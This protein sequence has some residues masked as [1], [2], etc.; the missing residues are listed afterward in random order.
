MIQSSSFI[1]DQ[2]FERERERERYRMEG[3]VC[4]I[5]K[6]SLDSAE[7]LQAHF[8]SQCGKV[9]ESEEVERCQRC[10]SEFGT[11]SSL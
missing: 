9:K 2:I 4:P 8:Q 7:L 3:F 6:I 11:L 1:F 5:C 10:K